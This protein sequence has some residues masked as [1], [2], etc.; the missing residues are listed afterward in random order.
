M[1]SASEG[2]AAPLRTLPSSGV[3]AQ[4]AL[5]PEI[6]RLGVVTSTQSV[7]FELADNGAPDRTVVVADTQTAGRGRRGRHW[8]DEPGASL[9]ASIVI[10]PRLAIRDLPKLSL[11]MGV[12]VAD[13]VA[14]VAGLAVRLKWPNDL[15]VDGRK[16]AGI[17][18]ESR[19]ATEALVVVGVGVNL[20]QHRFPHELSGTATSVEL[21]TGRTVERD[22][23]LEAVLAAFDAWRARLQTE[24]FAPVRDRWLDL[25]DTIGRRVTV[26]GRVGV[27]VDLDGDGALVI[28]DAAGVQHVVVGEVHEVTGGGDGCRPPSEIDTHGGGGYTAPNLVD[29]ARAITIYGMRGQGGSPAEGGQ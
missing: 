24:G 3:P 16:I 26:D 28:R 2:G 23:M 20:A 1:P 19:I 27:A 8:L 4:P 18:L 12:A 25:A 11:A 7:A 14:A 5:G 10:R 9:L 22:A 6:V 21:E 17:L 15:V 29:G 13:A